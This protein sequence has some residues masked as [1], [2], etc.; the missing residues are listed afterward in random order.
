[1]LSGYFWC[2]QLND[3]TKKN[4][5]KK[6][7]EACVSLALRY[8]MTLANNDNGDQTQM[9]GTKYKKEQ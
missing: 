3:E 9:N 1:M 7:S 8:A 5:N 4:N 2:F 6:V